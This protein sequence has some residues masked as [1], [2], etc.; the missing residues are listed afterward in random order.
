MTFPIR[1]YL[2]ADA[3]A[4]ADIFREAI[5]ELASEHYDED[6]RAAWMAGANDEDDF[7]QRLE[8]Q[9]TIVALDAGEPAAFISLKDNAVIDMLYVYPGFARE[10]AASTLMDAVVKIAAARGAKSLTADVSDNAKPFFEK[11][12][13]VSQ[14]RNIL[15]RED[16]ALGNTTMIKIL[17]PSAAAAPA[18]GAKN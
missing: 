9:L 5:W 15:M 13:F 18:S 7:A 17:Q 6:Q 16:E 14:R 2:P 1:P 12:G 11:F 10:G 4:C 8:T 3:S